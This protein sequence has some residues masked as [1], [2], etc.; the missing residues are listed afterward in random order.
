MA[1]TRLPNTPSAGLTAYR[2]QYSAT[3]ALIDKKAD[4]AAHYLFDVGMGNHG[5]PEAPRVY[6]DLSAAEKL[7]ILDKYVISTILDASKSYKANVDANA[8]RDAAITAEESEIVT[9]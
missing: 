4:Q 6:A 8:A 5:T 9:P 1:L 2:F 7:A 3:T